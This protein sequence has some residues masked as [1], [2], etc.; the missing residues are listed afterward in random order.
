[1]ARPPA[2]H[3]HKDMWAEVRSMEVADCM[4]WHIAPDVTMDMLSHTLYA[5]AKRA[6]PSIKLRVLRHKE[7]I[8]IVRVE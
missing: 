6:T 7:H 3:S 4:R 2:Y 8:F 1:M 5:Y